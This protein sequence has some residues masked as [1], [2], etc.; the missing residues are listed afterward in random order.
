MHGFLATSR[1]AVASGKDGNVWH[2]CWHLEDEVEV[3]ELRGPRR[4]AVLCKCKLAWSIFH[5]KFQIKTR[6]VQHH[7]V[8]ENSR[9]VM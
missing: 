8:G 5:R 9:R 6:H 7:A 3:Q 4:G 1:I 2:P